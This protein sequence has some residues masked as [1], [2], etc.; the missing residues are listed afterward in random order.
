MAALPE[1]GTAVLNGDDARVRDMG[2]VTRARKVFYGL[3]EDND[4]GQPIL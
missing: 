1:D 3:G 4:L 2:D